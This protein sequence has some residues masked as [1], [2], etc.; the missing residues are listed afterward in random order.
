MKIN[1]QSPIEE[2]QIQIIPLIDVVFCVLTF[3]LLASLQF[4]RQQAINVDLPKSSTGTVVQDTQKLHVTVDATGQVYLEQQPVRIEQLPQIIQNY[5]QQ[6]PKS[7][8]V[9]NASPSAAYNEVL[10]VLDILRQVG[11]DRAA[12]GI[13]PGPSSQVDN[14]NPVSPN[15]NN[16]ASVPLPN[17]YPYSNPNST[18]GQVPLPPTSGQNPSIPGINPSNP[19]LPPVI[20]NSINPS[21]PNLPPVI[22]NNQAPVNQVPKQ[23]VPARN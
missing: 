15:F 21:N 16:P 12:L 17:S 23:K 8:L 1:L 14:P 7:L 5:H 13:S 6:N 20:P 19:N 10:Q 18:G 11:G 9:L 22:P 2:V 3:F 4:T